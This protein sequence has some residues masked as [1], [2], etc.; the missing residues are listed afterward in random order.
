MTA[1]KHLALAANPK[2]SVNEPPD[3][4]P[5]LLISETDAL[6]WYLKGGH[7]DELVY[8]KGRLICDRDTDFMGL[9]D[10]LKTELRKVADFMLGK[11]IAGE[12]G[13]FQRCVAPFCFEYA[14]V[15]PV[16]RGRKNVGTESC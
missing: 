5:E 10:K 7:Q 15:C 16:L 3:Y 6:R 9:S 2:Q 4:K 13:L 11:A 12:V 1:P 14:A 8:H